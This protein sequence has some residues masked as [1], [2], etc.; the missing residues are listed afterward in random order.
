MS[1]LKKDSDKKTL[2]QE[3]KDYLGLDIPKDYFINSKK[4]ILKNI[5]KAEGEVKPIRQFKSAYFYPIA[6]SL[7]LA[8]GLTFW[9]QDN[10]S[11][12]PIEFN[13]MK[14]TQF[15]P[16]NNESLVASLFVD[17]SDMDNFLDAYVMNE[18]ILE[19]AIEEYNLD[20]IFINSFFVED[21]LIDKYFDEN[22]IES[23]LL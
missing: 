20:A 4:N 18:I 12:T 7:L 10:K 11:V 21:S 9:I 2:A 15:S 13:K 5:S 16:E 1:Y 19:T 17:E 3:H 8:L 22:I 6:A 14:M 23:M